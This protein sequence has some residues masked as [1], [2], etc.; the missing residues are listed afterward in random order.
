MAKP[1]SNLKTKTPASASRCPRW[2]KRAADLG[3]RQLSRPKAH[4]D[5]TK[6]IPEVE[7]IGDAASC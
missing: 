4:D 3:N 7:L 5:Y 6:E 2:L 1:T